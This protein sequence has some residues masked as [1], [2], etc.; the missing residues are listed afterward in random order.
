ML[1][2]VS[3]HSSYSWV[4]PHCMSISHF[5]PSSVDGQRVVSPLWLLQIMLLWTFV[6]KFLVDMFSFLLSIFLRVDLLDAAVT[7]FNLVRNCHAVFHTAPFYI[8]M[9]NVSG[10]Q[11]VH[12][13]STL[14]MLILCF[15]LFFFLIVA[16]LVSMK[17]IWLYSFW[18]VFPK[19]LRILSIFSNAYWHSFFVL[20]FH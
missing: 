18:F 14:V 4:I 1:Y 7:L 6:H 19:W 11:F 12:I 10:F 20:F 17:Y 13:F 15:F 5:F 2:Q 3:I 8:P 16:I 9:R